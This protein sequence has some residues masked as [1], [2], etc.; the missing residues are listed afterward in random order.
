MFDYQS[1]DV[2][3]LVRRINALVG[4]RREAIRQLRA[5][6]SGAVFDARDALI[7]SMLR[8]FHAAF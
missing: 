5:R 4:E 7:L 6:T 2:N 1:E 3:V 8:C